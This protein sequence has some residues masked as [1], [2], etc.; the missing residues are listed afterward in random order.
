MDI[1]RNL[2]SLQ[3][4]Y[5][6]TTMEVNVVKTYNNQFKKTNWQNE[7][8]KA[9]LIKEKQALQKYI[10]TRSQKNSEYNR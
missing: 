4:Y 5:K 2:E 8:V 9:E 1:G 10:H 6:N 7:E 3:K